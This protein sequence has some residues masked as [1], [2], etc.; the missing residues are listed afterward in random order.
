MATAQSPV[1]WNTEWPNSGRFIWISIGSFLADET[2]KN[3]HMQMKRSGTRHYLVIPEECLEISPRLPSLRKE[4]APWEFLLSRFLRILKDS[5]TQSSQRAARNQYSWTWRLFCLL[6][7]LLFLCLFA[8][9]F[10]IVWWA[11]GREGKGEGGV[12]PPRWWMEKHLGET[13]SVSIKRS[14]R[15]SIGEAM[16]RLSSRTVDLVQRCRRNGRCR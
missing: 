2:G 14:W 15:P 5:L 7:L 10:M 13:R 4:T 12:I 8:F 3:L 16:K 9:V 11:G 1:K 6:R